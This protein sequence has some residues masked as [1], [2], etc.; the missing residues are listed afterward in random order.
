MAYREHAEK[1]IKEFNQQTDR[2]DVV[3]LIAMKN[4]LSNKMME[5]KT[6]DGE[7]LELIEEDAGISKELK[8]TLKFSDCVT[9]A[10]AKI[11]DCISKIPST[12]VSVP[13]FNEEKKAEKTRSKL[14][15]LIVPSFSGD[16]LAFRGFWDQYHAAIHCKP[17]F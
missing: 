10:V 1:L 4:C 11:D 3:A 13:S 8:E 2:D 6:L 14:P 16:I 15:R 12:V 17:D 7:I 5:I 9:T